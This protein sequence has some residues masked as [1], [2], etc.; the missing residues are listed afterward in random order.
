MY[1]YPTRSDEI[2][3]YGIKRR[4]GR[5]PWGSGERPYQGKVFSFSKFKTNLK[6]L[7]NKPTGNYGTDKYIDV[8]GPYEKKSDLKRKSSNP[9][10]NRYANR[11]ELET[12]CSM[13]NKKGDTSKDGRSMN[14][15]NCCF[16]M[17]M[18]SKGYDVI[19]RSTDY[20]IIDTNEFVEQYFPGAV[21]YKIQTD[22]DKEDISEEEIKKLIQDFIKQQ[23][24]GSYGMMTLT[25]LD[26]NSG[27][28]VFYKIEDG[29]MIIYDGQIAGKG[30]I[31]LYIDK[32]VV[33]ITTFKFFRLDN[34]EPSDEIGNCVVSRK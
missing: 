6:K 26:G 22:K 33:D 17:V 23:E 34:A 5:Y 11:T 20:G 15:V 32:D 27:H 4:S 30:D 21:V 10:E 24:N 2:Y 9:D 16:A 8:D 29:N 1:I 14:C 25:W 28:A 7:Y 13:V 31:S 19:A 12:D 3:H 18:R